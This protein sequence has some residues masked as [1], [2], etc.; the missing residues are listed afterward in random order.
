MTALLIAMAFSFNGLRTQILEVTLVSASNDNLLNQTLENY[1]LDSAWTKEAGIKPTQEPYEGG[2]TPLVLQYLSNE[3]KD[4]SSI[5]F[6]SWSTI[7]RVEIKSDKYWAIKA[8]F[9]SLNTFGEYSQQRKVFFIK[10]NK[11]AFSIDE[12]LTNFIQK[13]KLFPRSAYN[14]TN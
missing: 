9:E 3:L 6:Q 13:G 5:R 11:V 1:S 8:E 12:N 7:D 4:P 10:D 2:L 14:G